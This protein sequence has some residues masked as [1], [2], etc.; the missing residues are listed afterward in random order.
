LNLKDLI[1]NTE[2]LAFVGDLEKEIGEITCDSREVTSQAL[3]VAVPGFK[4][5]G[6]QYI[7]DAL[8][9]GAAAVVIENERYRSEQ[10][11]WI[12][13]TNSRKALADLSSAFYGNPGRFLNVIGVTGTNGKTTTT[14]LIADILE[15]AGHRVGLVGTIHNKIGQ[16]ILPVNHTTPEAPE[17]QKLFRTFLDKGADYGVMEVSSHA[18]ELQRVKNVEFDVAVFTNLTQDHLDFHQNM[19]N[20]L[21][22]KGKLFSSLGQ[23]SY[24]ER[25]KFAI[26][27]AD[28]PY[29]EA[30]AELTRG[31]VITYGI[32]NDADVK[33]E[34]VKIT[35][36]G[37]EYLLKYTNQ[38]LLVR[39][40]LTG[41]FN[42]YNSL[43][44]IAVGLVEGIS[45]EQIIAALEKIPGIPGRFEKV[46]SD[47]DRAGNY[48][49]IVDYSHTP[50]SLEIC[51]KTARSFARGRVIVV[52]GCGGDR[53]KTKRPL[54]G[55]VAGRLA[56]LC[57]VTSDNPRSEDPEK[58]IDEIIPGLEKGVG[59]CPYLRITDRKKAI[60]KAIKEAK[61]E[62]VVII[63]G[64]G[65]EDYQIIGSRV[66]HFDDRE[67]AK[68]ALGQTGKQKN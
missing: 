10:Y 9:R 13:V 33:A 20:Y 7:A 1:H 68:A 21:A 54:M 52:F 61:P 60:F 17:L 44:A 2:V 48:T 42:V 27:N 62:D 41:L 6:H 25:R 30:L 16:E 28:D 12:Q 59:K 22:A 24:K 23:H 15:K 46:D 53:D 58:I 63:A 36:E 67:V 37:V 38:E 64:K 55:E 19:E 56:D 51:I 18:L 45:A 66:I 65:H 3:F 39:L 57:L 5:D 32:K 40:K 29:A 8:Q 14:N 4:T 11:V 35:H 34:K 43:A 47:N 50:D 31:S 49:V 26:L